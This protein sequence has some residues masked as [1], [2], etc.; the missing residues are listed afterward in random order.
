VPLLPVFYIQGL[1]S[2]AFT[3]R[4][5]YLS[6]VGFVAILAML[7]TRIGAMAPQGTTVLTVLLVLLTGLYSSGTIK[8]N[9]VWKSDYTL[10]EDTLRKSPD[11]AIT[12]EKFATALLERNELDESIKHY[13]AAITLDYSYEDSHTNLAI[14]L[15]RKGLIDQAIEE[16]RVA[17]TLN[18]NFP[19]THF[20]L[21]QQLADRQLWAEA[22]QE[23]RTAV[24][25]DPNFADAHNGL[26]FS[27]AMTGSVDKAIEHFEAARRLAPDNPMYQKNLARALKMKQDS[28]EPG[29]NR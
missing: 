14:A 18:P 28:S 27:Y 12:H 8:R 26:A 5:L 24:S 9:A 22:V 19:E 20:N 15:Y 16:G 2:N 7:L 23:Y 13:R 25:L 29:R 17:V 10:F 3:E 1:G 21:A 11:S 6:S 4:Y